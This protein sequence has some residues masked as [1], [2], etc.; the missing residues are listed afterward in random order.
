M[1]GWHILESCQV[2]VLK[3]KPCSNYQHESN[4]ILLCDKCEGSFHYIYLVSIKGM[5]LESRIL[6]SVSCGKLSKVCGKN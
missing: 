1:K 4:F 2:K 6:L 3:R 5:E